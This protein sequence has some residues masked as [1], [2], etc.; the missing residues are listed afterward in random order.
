M[1][2]LI[3]QSAKRPLL[4]AAWGLLA[5]GI[6]S[7]AEKVYTIY[8]VP[9]SQEAVDCNVSISSDKISIVAGNEIDNPTKSRVLGI[10]TEHALVSG[11]GENIFVEAPQAGE[12]RILLGVNGSGDAA[13]TRVTELG[14]SRNVFSKTNKYDKHILHIGIAATGETEIIILGENTDA[15]F[16]GL[17]SLEQILDAYPTGENIPGGNLYDYADQKN[18]GIVEGYYGV[19]YSVDV[20]KDLMRFMMRFKMNTYMYGAKSDPYH[21]ANWK[22]AYPTKITDQQK[23][24]GYLSQSMVT[25]ITT[26]SSATKVNFVWAIH[27]GNSFL[28]SSTVVSDILNKFGLMHNLGVRQFAVFVDDVSI[29]TTDEQYA[30]NATRVTDIQKGI[31]ARWNM[32]GA[33]PADTVKPLQFVPQIYCSSFAGGGEPQ[34][35][36][37][38]TAL[39]HTPSNVAIY[40]TG[41]GVWSVPNTSDVNQVKQYLNRDV[42]WWWNYPCNDNDADKIFPADMFSNFADEKH[43]SGS[44]RPDQSL[45]NCLG[46]LSNP[47]QQGEI[48]KIALFGVADYAWNNSGFSNAQNFAAALPA[49][50]G[51]RRAE[52]FAVLVPYLRYFDSSAISAIVTSYEAG[53]KNNR[54]NSEVLA[55]RMQNIVNAVSV[56]QEMENSENESD[57]LFYNDLKPWLLRLNEMAQLTLHLLAAA[58]G[59]TEE[60]KWNNYAPTPAGIASLDV[61]SRFKAPQLAGSVG[62]NLSISSTNV[63]PSHQTLM[64]F[65]IRMQDKAIAKLFGSVPTK[66]VF[67]SNKEGAKGSTVYRKEQYS[68]QNCTNTLG[69]G[70]YVGAELINPTRLALLTVSDTLNPN[71]RVQLSPD[72]KNW[73]TYTDVDLSTEYVKHIRVKNCGEDSLSVAL[74]T[75]TL[76]FAFPQ[77]TVLNAASTTIPSGDIWDNHDK[78]YLT[79][80]DYST[81]TCLYRN[82]Q[83]NDAYTV[84]L[85]K[86][87]PVKDVRIC[88]GTVNGDYM[89]TGR[90]QVSADGRKWTNLKIK[91]TNTTDFK[92][93][94]PKVVKYSD[95]M[96]YCDFSGMADTVQYVR[97]YLSAP[98]TSK[99]IRIYEIEVNKQ[100]YKENFVPDVTDAS[101]NK[102]D[103]LTDKVG[104][105]RYDASEK[106][107]LVYWFYHA[108]P[109][110]SAKIFSDIDN[111]TSMTYS[112]RD[113]DSE[114]WTEAMPVTEKCQTVDLKSHPFAGAMKI[115]WSGAAPRIYEIISTEDPN[116]APE[117]VGI[118]PVLGGEGEAEVSVTSS[119]G[120]LC[121]GSVSSLKNVVLYSADGRKLVAVEC[122]NAR[123]VYLPVSS[124]IHG[125]CVLQVMLANGQQKVVKVALR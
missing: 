90:V 79:D 93:S 4:L 54:P 14:L 92:M 74:K 62:A 23:E 10:L 2:K 98:N 30:L 41:W 70:E 124:G 33:A 27:P 21:S 9:H 26:T 48:S 53:L 37:F 16:I 7:M 18:R 88:M 40:T 19:P 104:Y 100:S 68:F 8:P 86:P 15:T 58:E 24:L 87:E 22:D 111:S 1:K 125:V 17:A 44:A 69:K 113:Y 107:S 36:A 43:I 66:P 51:D 116:P 108:N 77:P 123:E 76:A 97:L 25:D 105:T 112:I 119:H 109:L 63:H 106:G 121:I 5:F 47:M 94:N 32:E 75:S 50:L 95:E 110:L 35:K 13:D 55:G 20:K 84:K 71:L 29:P 82:Q 64:P 91:G 52:A 61:D 39:S 57:R 6:P 67:V 31:E 34:R 3:R 80:G 81:F 78:T 101:G 42:A 45:T 122:G 96:S 49:V 72:G 117:V 59:E 11:N 73:K 83:A 89:N 56:I 46:V 12:T 118:T 65:I 120:A 60:D 85:S 102:V 38:F 28:G 114:E 115:E 103:E 99:W